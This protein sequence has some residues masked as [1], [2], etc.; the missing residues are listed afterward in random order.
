[1][2]PEAWHSCRFAALVPPWLVRAFNIDAAARI[3]EWAADYVARVA[4]N[5]LLRDLDSHNFQNQNTI[6][7]NIKSGYL[8]FYTPNADLNDV[9]NPKAKFL[10]TWLMKHL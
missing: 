7:L 8:Q 1:M 10:R 2:T 3:A 6:T 9:N 4:W 5:D